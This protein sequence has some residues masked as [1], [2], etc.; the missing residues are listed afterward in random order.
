MLVTILWRMEGSPAF[1]Q[2]KFNDL[3]ENSYYFQAVNWAG[4]NGIVNGYANGSF[5]PGN[6]ITREQLAVILMNYAKY[7][8]K[9][10][11]KTTDITGYKD[12][13]SVSNYAKIALSWGVANKVLSG[14]DNATRLDPKGNA[15]RAEAAAMLT[16]YCNNIGR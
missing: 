8:G 14:K 6:N 1:T 9:D 4:S 3:R 10:L 13:S 5:K 12:Y 11:S 2:A 16:N 15:S 7:K